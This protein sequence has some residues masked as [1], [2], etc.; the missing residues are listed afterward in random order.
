[1][2]CNI[3]S[4]SIVIFCLVLVY[5]GGIDNTALY[6]TFPFPLVLFAMLG[7]LYGSIT[8]GIVFVSLLLMLNNQEL[9]I[10][11]YSDIEVIRF[12]SSFFVVNILSFIN[13][14]FREH[15]HSAMTDINI[16]KE[17]QAN[18]DILTNLPNRRFIDAV[19]IPASKA[20]VPNRFPMVLIMGDVDYF[21]SFNDNYG[22][23][24]GDLI[25]EKLA[26]TME[27]SIRDED[28][29]SR[30][31]GE[32]FLIFFSNTDYD[33]GMKIAEKMR[34]AVSGMR[35]KHE[36]KELKITMSFGVAIAHSYNEIDSKLKEADEKLYQAKNAGRNC[37]C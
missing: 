21:K 15:S 26:R 29:V 24:T 19:F 37:V 14:Y 36:T 32:E 22:H 18:T 10:A 27:Q 7:Y 13:E 33:T 11:H 23:Q 28:I 8:N 30:V 25:L 31:G 5:Q 20:N 6:W 9:L 2:S 1:M 3:I 12:L 34:S 16:T 4:L 17:Q 35:L